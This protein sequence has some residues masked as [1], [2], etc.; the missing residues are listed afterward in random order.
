MSD[1]C[2]YVVRGAKTECS[3]GSHKRKINLPISHG[4][5]V[6]SKPMMNEQDNKVE[7]NISY[8][9]ICDSPKNP[10]NE[11]IYLAHEDN[12]STISGKR[13]CPKILEKWDITKENTKVEGKPA[14][15]TK[16]QLIC[17]Y[18]GIITFVND[19]QQEE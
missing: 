16:S 4:S 9:G 19:G 15:T 13:C 17:A 5:Y 11:T 1:S 2:K 8:F 18:D 14:L 6:N 12:G 3:C 10:N 7:Q